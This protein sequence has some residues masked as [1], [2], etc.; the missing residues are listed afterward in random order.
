MSGR[1]GRGGE[2]G[3]EGRGVGGEGRGVGGEGRGGI[4]ITGAV[5]CRFGRSDV[6]HFM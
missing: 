1:E 4:I 2:V 5:M 3:G 6:D